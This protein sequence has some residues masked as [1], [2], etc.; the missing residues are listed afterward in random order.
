MLRAL[1]R[2]AGAQAAAGLLEKFC[3]LLIAAAKLSL[4]GGI[5]D[6]IPMGSNSFRCLLFGLEPQTFGLDQSF[7][8]GVAGRES[9]IHE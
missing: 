5:C 3:G 4:P 9:V 8:A 1:G 7:N 2:G 6:A